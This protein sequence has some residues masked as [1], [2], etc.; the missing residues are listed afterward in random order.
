MPI[1]P[2]N[3]E[4]FFQGYRREFGRVTPAQVAALEFLLARLEA[5]PFISDPRHAGYMLA[6]VA[7]ETARTF[8]P[9]DERGTDAYFNR[10]YGPQTGTGKR[11]G[12]T[13]PGDGARYHGRGY[14]QLTGRANYREMGERLSLDLEGEPERVK[15]REVA[16]DVMSGGMRF[17]SFTGKK[18][19][20]YINARKADYVNARRIINGTDRASEIADIAE[21]FVGV[22][23]EAAS[24]P[25]LGLAAADPG[26]PAA[27]DTGVSVAA[28]DH[29]TTTNTTSN[30][31]G[32]A[33]TVVNTAP[34]TA[35]AVDGGGKDDAGVS[36][37]KVSL[38]TKMTA[39]LSGGTVFT[40]VTDGVAK[41]TGL[42]PEAQ[43]FVF[44]AA[45]VFVGIALAAV[46]VEH[47]MKQWIKSRPDRVNIKQ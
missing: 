46:A 40:Y 23:E 8:E 5:D 15:D 18:L 28:G 3:R 14:V 17:G 25:V 35:Q 2:L 12:N 22:L 45:V 29:S 9:I 20:D 37:N 38:W 39:G 1:K 43:V 6:T 47:L 10:R 7:W 27:A 34:Q 19:T 26:Q 11:L 24:S 31:V 16:Y 41:M 44:K 13:E 36:A 30:V 4:V 21:G 33:Q 32:E 42:A